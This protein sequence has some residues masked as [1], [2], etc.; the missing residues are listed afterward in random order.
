MKAQSRVYIK[1]QNIYK[2][3]ARQDAAEVLQLVQSA[4][5]GEDIDATE[6]DLFCKNAAFVKLINGSSSGPAQLRQAIGTFIS[7]AT[8]NINANNC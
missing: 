6:V 2:A 3:K 4:P 5:G 1:L 8:R 7:T